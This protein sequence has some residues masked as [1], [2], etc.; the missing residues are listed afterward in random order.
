M[1]GRGRAGSR[2]AAAVLEALRPGEPY[3]RWLLIFD[4]ADEPD[5][6]LDIIPQGSRDALITSRNNRWQ[7]VF[8]TLYLN[9]FA[10]GRK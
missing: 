1:R 7:S 3:S 6:L 4:N 5:E 9:V 8:D 10:R 2:V